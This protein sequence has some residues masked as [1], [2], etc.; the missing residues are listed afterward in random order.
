MAAV[1]GEDVEAVGGDMD[2]CTGVPAF[3]IG[4]EV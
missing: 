3:K 4:R 1:A 2:I